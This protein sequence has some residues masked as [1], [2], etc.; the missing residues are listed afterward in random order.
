MQFYFEGD[1]FFHAVR[2]ALRSAVQSI[3]I[4][5]Y[6]LAS[7]A[8][9]F[10]FT[11]LLSARALA[12]IRV[13]LH[14]DAV[15]CRMT[16]K[17]MFL[18]LESCGV[19][20]KK[21]NPLIPFGRH[22]GRRNHRKM[23]IIDGKTVFIGGYNLACEY[24]RRASGEQ[25]WRD[26]GV[27]LQDEALS[28]DAVRL[29][30]ELWKGRIWRLKEFL[31]HP[32]GRPPWMSR[33]CHLIA[34]HG[35]QRKSPIREEYLSAIIHAGKSI[36]VTNP[37]F[38]PDRGIRRALCRAAK[39]GVDVRLLTTGPTDVW[40]AKIAGQANYTQF[41]KAGV[42]IFEFQSRVLHAKSAVID[43]TWYT[44]GTSNMDHLSFFRNLE[45]N[46]VG[47]STAAGAILRSQFERDLG[48]SEEIRLSAWR[49]RGWWQRVLERIATLFR[50]WL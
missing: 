42:R 30:E 46:V 33:D 50:V 23:F 47:R 24:S 1:D 44:V 34:N 12:G 6:Y 8:L 16:D 38:I 41:L 43:Q 31:L 14:Y 5:I 13:R 7:D 35:L 17:G 9:G 48:S 26:S 2:E 27:C 49:A 45:V 28:L 36:F 22:F 25:A 39:R 40:I 29:F 15:G 20:V 3:D 4:E 32:P 21:Y 18:N 37:Y 19:K 11:E 10:E